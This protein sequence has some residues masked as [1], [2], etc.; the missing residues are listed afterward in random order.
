MKK[1]LFS[2]LLAV[3]FLACGCVNIYTTSP[4]SSEASESTSQSAQPESATTSQS[5]SEPS[6]NNSL[7]YY[8]VLQAASGGAGQN[9]SVNYAITASSTHESMAGIGYS[10]DNLRDG[11]ADTAWVEGASG[12]GVGQTL[13]LT[14]PDVTSLKGFCIRNGYAKTDKSFAENGRAQLIDVSTNGQSI[15]KMQ[16]E[17]DSG[18]QSFVLSQ[19]D[20]IVF[21][22]GTQ[23][24]LTLESTYTGPQDGELDTAISDIWMILD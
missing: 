17:N 13:T 11:S 14:L 4:E 22:A 21:P 24:T 18:L 15:F 8:G 6:G 2:L 23:L 3:M 9:L 10:P 20:F 1:T 12:D 7:D 16:L 5:Q 19:T